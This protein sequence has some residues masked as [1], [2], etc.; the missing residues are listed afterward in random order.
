MGA[1][2]FKDY[3]ESAFVWVILKAFDGLCDYPEEVGEKNPLSPITLLYGD[4]M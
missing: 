1:V 2:L 4:Y 3:F